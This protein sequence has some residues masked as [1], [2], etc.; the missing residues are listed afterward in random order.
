MENLMQELV[1][2]LAETYPQLE[3][4]AFDTTGK[5]MACSHKL[6]QRKL[7]S[8]PHPPKIVRGS[9]FT[10]AIC[11]AGYGTLAFGG[12]VTSAQ[13]AK[14][15]YVF[16]EHCIQILREK[17]AVHWQLHMENDA[18]STLLKSLFT[19][20]SGEDISYIR[21]SAA[22]KGYDLSLKRVIILIQIIPSEKAG[23]LLDS[24]FAALPDYV[25]QM[26]FFSRQDI[27]GWGSEHQ[28]VICKALEGST[29]GS[30]REQFYEPLSN[31][32]SMLREKY[33]IEAQI[34][35]S[36]AVQT[37][38]SYASCLTAAQKTLTF[39]KLFDDDAKVHFYEDYFLETEISQMPRKVLEHF[40]A[41]Y[42]EIVRGSSWMEETLKVLIHSNMRLDEAADN[43]Y[44]HRNTL[45]FRLK[46]IRKLLRLDPVNRDSDYFTLL[47][48]YIY[49]CL[50]HYTGAED[51]TE[52]GKLGPHSSRTTERGR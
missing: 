7:S 42:I 33:G 49:M 26:N 19:V 6:T 38:Y 39:S 25:K 31:L 43:L 9:S 15:I 21:L 3:A 40:F 1:Q 24:A 18:C 36:S 35:V 32:C 23:H 51:R 14:I 37:L 47:I 5:L 44:I 10:A 29:S 28:L 45:A 41:H 11:V 52:A 4:A 22:A 30:V 17:E 2:R 48:L 16:A 46:Q 50:Y 27:I 8:K 34:S 12:K 13:E 20:T